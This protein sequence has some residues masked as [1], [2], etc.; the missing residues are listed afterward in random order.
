MNKYTAMLALSALLPSCIRE[1]VP[2]GAELVPGDSLPQFS[3]VMNDGARVSTPDLLGEVSVIV[4]FNTDCPDCR[5]ELPVLQELQG[6]YGDSIELLCISRE[7]GRAEIE[8]YWETHGLTLPYSPQ[9][10]R[11]VYSQFSRT[12]IP[13][14][15]ISSGDLVIRSV[16]GDDPVAGYDDLVRD[17]EGL[18]P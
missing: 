3:V 17:I 6:N 12:G 1:G 9:E 2:G 7:Q 11:T 14:V 18:L 15:F 13:K 8:A 10:D 16:H 5:E 4:F